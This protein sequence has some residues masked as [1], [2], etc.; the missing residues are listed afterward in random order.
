[1]LLAVALFIIVVF[2]YNYYAD[3]FIEREVVVYTTLLEKEA[4]A[5]IEAFK[6]EHPGI[7]ITLQRPPTET[8]DRLLREEEGPEVDVIWG[9]DVTSLYPL[10]WKGQLKGYMPKKKS[11]EEGKE[12]N[13]PFEFKI[14]YRDNLNPPKWFGLDIWMSAFCVNKHDLEKQ[15]LAVPKSWKDLLDKSYKGKIV[16]PN[17]NTSGTGYLTVSAMLQINENEALGWEYLDQLNENVVHYTSNDSKSCDSVKE[18]KYPIGISSD[19]SSGAVQWVKESE[20]D[21]FQIIFPSDGSGWE[22]NSSALVYKDD[23]KPAAKTF[24]NWAVSDRAR[25]IYAQYS[26]V[27]S[28]KANNKHSISEIYPQPIKKQLLK[29]DF[30]RYA[31]NREK[32]LQEWNKRYQEKIQKS[33]K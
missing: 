19:V 26:A 7:E 21:S 6:M 11:V 32:I 25:D 9:V 14:G 12:K 22:I 1:M 16:A 23:I 8:L 33:E 13:T 17:P 24:L 5:G 31:A 29:M 28:I 30:A 3:Y 4:K 10:G 27:L 18:G 15:G 2:F 20:D